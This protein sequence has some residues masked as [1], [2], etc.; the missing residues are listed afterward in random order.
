M[1]LNVSL[2][3]RIEVGAVRREEWDNEVVRTDGGQEVR[4]TRWSAPLRSYDIS[5]P[6][7]ST[8]GDLSDFNSVKQ[9]WSDTEGGTH[10]F[11][12]ND[13]VDSEQVKV[14]F[15]TPL[16]ITSDAGH[17]RHIDQFTLQEVRE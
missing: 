14:R 11:W 4:N 5:M 8:A 16:Q 15:S 9:I 2:P 7:T 17:L 6:V 13:W 1:H 3:T 12:F 10:T